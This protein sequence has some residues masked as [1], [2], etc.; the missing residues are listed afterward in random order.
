MA[1]WMVSAF[2]CSTLLPPS[3]C[4]VKAR[5][6]TVI[7]PDCTGMRA[8]RAAGY[9]WQI[10]RAGGA[11]DVHLA[12]CRMNGHALH[13]LVTGPAGKSGLQHRRGEPSIKSSDK[14]VG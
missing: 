4:G 10:K 6:I 9:P 12:A 11:R 3:Q 1:R 7:R 8:L 14:G 5:H 13:A 2:N